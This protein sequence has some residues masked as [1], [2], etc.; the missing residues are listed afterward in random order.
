MLAPGPGTIF[1]QAIVVDAQRKFG[2]ELLA[3]RTV[4][5]TIVDAD[6]GRNAVLVVPSMNS[7]L[8]RV[9]SFAAD[10]AEGA[11]RNGIVAIAQQTATMRTI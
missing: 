6:G 3:G 11:Y 8:S 10:S 4:G 1:A 5:V 2:L 7:P 9:R